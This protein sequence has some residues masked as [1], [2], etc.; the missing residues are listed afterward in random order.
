MFHPTPSTYF[1]NPYLLPY[2]AFLDKQRQQSSIFSN[3]E[4]NSPS[5]KDLDLIT[6][7]DVHGQVNNPIIS[8]ALLIPVCLVLV[9]PIMFIQMRTLKMLKGENTINS[10]M[11][12]TQL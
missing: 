3:E 12:V 11:M 7:L 5:Y 10:K 2:V 9:P 6:D 1:Y 8:L 4:E